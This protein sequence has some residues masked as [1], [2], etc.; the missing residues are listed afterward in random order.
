MD[1]LKY[2]P[3]PHD[4]KAFLEKSLKREGFKEE[5]DSLEDKYILIRE[6]LSARSR[7]GLTQEV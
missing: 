5:Y 3:V 4:H 6:M 1:D 2:N 7:S